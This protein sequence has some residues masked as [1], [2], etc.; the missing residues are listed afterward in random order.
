M[1]Q[2]RWI[3]SLGDQIDRLFRTV[4]EPQRKVI[5]YDDL[6]ADPAGV[7]NGIFDFL[8]VP[9]ETFTGLPRTNEFAVP[10]SLLI[11]DFI[12]GLQTITP[13]RQIRLRLKPPFNRVGFAPINWLW[14]ANLRVIPKPALARQLQATMKAEF[15][16]DVAK[17][18]CLLDRDFS[19]WLA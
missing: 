3:C 16:D 5:V 2:Y 9:R 6:L 15:A 13:F 14:R 1:L 18:G 10:R 7:L 4:P 12:Q 17:L 8:G 11:T 19:S